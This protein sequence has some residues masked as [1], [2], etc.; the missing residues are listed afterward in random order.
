M[1]EVD[2]RGKQWVI[3]RWVAPA[4]G[5]RDRANHGRIWDADRTRRL[6]QRYQEDETSPKANLTVHCFLLPGGGARSG[7]HHEATVA[8]PVDHL[9]AAII[10][11]MCRACAWRVH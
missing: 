3:V 5:R 7:V 11:G 4:G 9:P 6:R 8:S 1:R 2:R 10:S